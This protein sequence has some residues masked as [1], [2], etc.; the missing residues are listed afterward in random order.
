VMEMNDSAR[1]C[2]ESTRMGPLRSDA[3]RLFEFDACNS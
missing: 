2:G 1:L 3:S